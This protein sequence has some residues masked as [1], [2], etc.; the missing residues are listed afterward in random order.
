MTQYQ[1]PPHP[2]KP[3]HTELKVRCEIWMDGQVVARS[4]PVDS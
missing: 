4:D 1:Q 2:I 3:K